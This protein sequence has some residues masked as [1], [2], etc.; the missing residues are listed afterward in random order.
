MMLFSFA[1]KKTLL[2]Y[3]KETSADASFSDKYIEVAEHL[4]DDPEPR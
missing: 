4:L 2:P 1:V 3:R